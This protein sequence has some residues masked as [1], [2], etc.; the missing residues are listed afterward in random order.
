MKKPGKEERGHWAFQFGTDREYLEW[1]SS[2]PSAL[3]GA[4]NQILDGRGRCIA[5]HVRRV[6]R[7]AGTGIKPPFS[8]I[9][10]THGEHMTEGRVPLD[11][12]V[13]WADELLDLWVDG[14]KQGR[15]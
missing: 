3:S 2:R 7:G 10:L 8:A 15:W 5:C 13:R 1:L 4:F 12:R 11:D 9:P 6:S 14:R